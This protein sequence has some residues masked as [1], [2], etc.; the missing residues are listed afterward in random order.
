MGKRRKALASAPRETET[1]TKRIQ[2]E[3]LLSFN[4]SYLNEQEAAGQ[5]LEEWCDSHEQIPLL[6]SFIRKLAH[7]SDQNITTSMTEGGLALYGDFPAKKVTNFKC[8]A[9][10]ENK[11]WGTIRNVGGQQARV[12]GFLQD[13]TFF[14]VFLDK[15]HVFYKSSK[16]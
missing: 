4:F 7:L 5:S 2:T 14:P 6:V 8:P 11:K 9:G 13:Q 10:L 16:R 3:E 12:A 15:D 1:R